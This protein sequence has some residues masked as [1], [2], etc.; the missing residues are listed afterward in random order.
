MSVD[1]CADYKWVHFRGFSWLK[2]FFSLSLFGFYG[3][4]L[5]RSEIVILEE[6]NT[7]CGSARNEE[8]ADVYLSALI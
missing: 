1:S 6:L 5:E 7:A 8:H 4:L 2:F 3:L